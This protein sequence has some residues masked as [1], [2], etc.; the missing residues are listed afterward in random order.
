MLEPISDLKS[1]TQRPESRT[2][3]YNQMFRLVEVEKQ[4]ERSKMLHLQ[5]STPLAVFQVFLDAKV[6]VTFHLHFSAV[7]RRKK[8]KQGAFCCFPQHQDSNTM[9]TQNP[10]GD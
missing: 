3:H 7:R 5:V 8:R 4:L 6:G 1:S 2:S 9:D 10:S